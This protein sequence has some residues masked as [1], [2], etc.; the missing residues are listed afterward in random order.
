MVLDLP[1]CNSC[2][3]SEHIEGLDPEALVGEQEAVMLSLAPSMSSREAA[4]VM[5]NA[6]YVGEVAFDMRVLLNYPSE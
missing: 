1:R 3:R 4:Y 5:A 6:T 2:L